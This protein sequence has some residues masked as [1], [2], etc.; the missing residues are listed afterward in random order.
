MIYAGLE[1]FDY[2]TYTVGP[3]DASEI[4]NKDLDAMRIGMTEVGRVGA[5]GGAGRG[6]GRR[7]G[8]GGVR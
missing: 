6:M 5:E 4:I 8:G 3:L 1:P 2:R 7:S